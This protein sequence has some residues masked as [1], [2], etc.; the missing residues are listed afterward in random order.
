[1]AA[2][3]DTVQTRL[4]RRLLI[5]NL[6]RYV[7][8]AEST[9]SEGEF[10]AALVARTGCG[11]LLDVNNL[12]V[13]ALNFGE[14]PMHTVAALPAEAIF[15]LHIAGHAQGAG[16]LFIDTHGTPVCDAVWQ[17]L[18]AVLARIGPRPV[19]LER[20]T[21]LPPLEELLAERDRAQALLDAHQ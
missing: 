2:R 9:L 21:E 17:L 8:F 7:R 5:E 11:L 4:G 18:D 10:L 3:V 13:N 15:E 20:D 19:L 1:M 14:D 12:Y 16:G 6:S